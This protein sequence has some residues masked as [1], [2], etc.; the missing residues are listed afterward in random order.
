MNTEIKARVL[1]ALQAAF[2][3]C[4]AD[5][6]ESPEDIYTLWVRVFAVPPEQVRVIKNFI[7]RVASELPPAA[8]AILLP[9]VKN[10]DVTRQH[11][12]QF[13]PKVPAFRA[14]AFIDSV[15]HDY[16]EGGVAWQTLAFDVGVVE[17]F[18]VADLN[19]RQDFAEPLANDQHSWHMPGSI[20]AANTEMAKAA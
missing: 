11:Y 14:S 2:P 19:L 16:V 6:Q 1:R 4:P 3:E 15:F 9:M 10:Q 8:G 18:C 17:Q 12:P 7:H 20:N 5:V 13:M